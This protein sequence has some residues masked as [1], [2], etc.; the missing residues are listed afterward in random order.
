[1]SQGAPP[2]S[3]TEAAPP[4]DG[5]VVVMVATPVAAELVAEI[6]GVDGRL[7]VLFDERLL[8]PPRYPSDHRGRSDFSRD[9]NGQRRW[10]EM[11]TRVNV[12]YGI[13]GETAEG[14]ADVVRRAPHLRWVQATSAGVAEKVRAARLTSAERGRVA[15]S[16]AS[17]PHKVGLAE[18]AILGLLAD[19]RG[20]PWLVEGRA[21]RRWERRP[22]V[23]LRGR[24][25][26]VLGL[27]TIG[28]EIARLA[29][30]FGMTVIGVSRSAHRDRPPGVNQIVTFD[31]LDTV[32][33]GIDAVVLALP[34]S[35]GTHHVLSAERL[36]GLKPGCVV[37]NVGR[38]AAID[39]QA[40][41]SRLADGTVG[42][43]ALDVVE[44]E[45]LPADSPL[46]ELDNVLLSPHTAALTTDE[47]AHVT[48]LFC[49]NLT[50]FLAGRP[51]LNLV[52]PDL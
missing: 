17:G 40:L 29:A 3:G 8:P 22:N 7:Q 49:D 37:V 26:L 9:A 11:L 45:P 48:R 50:R 23:P 36:A 6:A 47:N 44:T 31:D 15:V 21:L 39:E 41:V 5:S 10:D 28:A 2:G 25:L 18:F 46:W 43:A 27:G 20:L 33:P 14:L 13:P 42:F 16:S 51:L 32:L 12:L 38:G 19:A 1:V 52:D 4:H 35:P 24:T 30:A 34:S